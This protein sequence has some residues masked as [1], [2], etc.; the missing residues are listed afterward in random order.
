MTQFLTGLKFKW[1][2][3]PR[4]HLSPL[5]DVVRVVC[6]WPMHVRDG[7]GAAT[8]RESH[9]VEDMGKRIEGERNV[10][11]YISISTT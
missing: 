1:D 6:S 7:V 10:L 8:V 2:L 4:Q 3:L 11:Q 9:P 5:A